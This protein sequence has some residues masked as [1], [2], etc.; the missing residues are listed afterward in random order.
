M[1]NGAQREAESLLLSSKAS[2]TEQGRGG[3]TGELEAIESICQL[4][5]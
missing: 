1:H 2:N 4:E 5:H 3:R